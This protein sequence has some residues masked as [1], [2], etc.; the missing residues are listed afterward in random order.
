MMS[1]TLNSLQNQK[2]PQKEIIKIFR[3]WSKLP[4][5]KLLSI[6]QRRNFV[7]EFLIDMSK[8]GA[9]LL[10]LLQ[11]I[12]VQKHP[13]GSLSFIEHT[14]FQIDDTKSH[15]LKRYRIIFN[16]LSDEIDREK[17]NIYVE[18]LKNMIEMFNENKKA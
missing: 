15:L 1:T 4:F 7:I 18:S 8:D 3:E 2:I 17:L 16:D 9:K 6:N 12:T 14:N 5:T 10:N 11:K 13:S